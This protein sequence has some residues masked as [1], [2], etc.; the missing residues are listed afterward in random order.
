MQDQ[1]LGV[2]AAMLQLPLKPL[3]AESAWPSESDVHIWNGS[4][5]RLLG[6]SDFCQ[7]LALAAEAGSNCNALQ[8][9]CMLLCMHSMQGALTSRVY[10]R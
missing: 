1:A 4:V 9:C 6:Q 5:D 10:A 3:N 7:L 8:Q 2:L